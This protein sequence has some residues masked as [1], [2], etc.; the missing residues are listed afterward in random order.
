MHPCAEYKAH[1]GSTGARERGFDVRDSLDKKTGCW[2]L[3]VSETDVKS[4]ASKH[5]ATLEHID[6]RDW[7]VR[8][9]WQNPFLEEPTHKHVFNSRFGADASCS[10]DATREVI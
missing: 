6:L 5:I 7:S 4:I 1:G 10:C 3:V 9:L 2:H 8:M